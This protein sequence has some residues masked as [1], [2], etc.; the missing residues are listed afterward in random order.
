MTALTSLTTGLV[1]YHDGHGGSVGRERFEIAR[2]AGGS[3]VRALCELDDIGLLRDMTLTLDPAGR[4][5]DAFCRILKDGRTATTSWYHCEADAVVY[6]GVVEGERLSERFATDGPPAYLGLHPIVGDALVAP[7]RGTDAPGE[8]R[9]IAGIT[10]SVSPNGDEGLRPMRTVIDVAYVGEEPLTV[11][12]GQFQARRHAL[13]WRE[14]W[15]PADL[16]TRDGDGLFLALRWSMIEP[17]YELVSVEE[18]GASPP[19]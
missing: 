18:R 15:P 13:R 9:G 3:T 16:W 12:A 4:P 2:D 1:A 11:A 8:Y 5:R 6:E 19:P 10:Y 14:D 7:L 17:W